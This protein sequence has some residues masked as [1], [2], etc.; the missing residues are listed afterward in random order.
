MVLFTN[1]QQLLYDYVTANT[2]S[3]WA[4]SFI[5]DLTLTGYAPIE[6][7]PTPFLDYQHVVRS[8]SRARTRILFLDY[9]VHY[10]CI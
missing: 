1:H 8:F 6:S 2:A 9:D 4:K 7:N 3:F 5:G 10:Q